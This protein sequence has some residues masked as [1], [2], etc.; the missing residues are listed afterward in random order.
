LR[1]RGW[2]PHDGDGDAGLG[3]P[4]LQVVD[5]QHVLGQQQA[6]RQRVIAAGQPAAIRTV[7]AAAQR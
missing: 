1:G 3:Q 2:L 4:R 5:R 6:A 7:A